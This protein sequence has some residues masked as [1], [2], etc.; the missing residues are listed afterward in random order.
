MEK[1][2][3]AIITGASSGLGRGLALWFAKQGVRV[4]AAARRADKLK[5]LEDEAKAV[6]G[7]VE[8]VQLDVNDTRQ[9]ITKLNELDDQ[10]GGLDLVI[11]NAGLGSET[12][13]K[14]L[15]WDV[16]EQLIQ[17]NVL[18]A[19][20]TLSAVVPK[21]VERQRG[22]IVGVSSIAAYRGLPKS[23]GYSASKAFVM[24]FLEGLRIDLVPLGIQVTCINPGFVKSE[25]TEKNKFKMPFIL[26]TEDAVERIAQ[27]I[28][29]GDSEFA[30]PG[31]LVAASKV[32]KALPNGLWDR[33]SRKM[34]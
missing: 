25:M 31:P 21:M 4:F 15:K 30:F 34:R 2:R 16:V 5:S 23:A 14:R 20:A 17:T 27:A 24:V 6:G 8:A 33:M 26:E 18:G 19:A 3:N 11:A 1:Y 13:G 9:V 28:V 12:N 7:T 22:H 32:M 10:S 29:R